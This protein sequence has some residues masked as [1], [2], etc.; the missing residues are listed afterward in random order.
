MYTVFFWCKKKVMILQHFGCKCVRDIIALKYV[1]WSRE[2]TD[3]PV[4]RLHA[5]S[6]DQVTDEKFQ[7]QLCIF[8]YLLLVKSNTKSTIHICM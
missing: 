8:C 4:M 3:Y 1:L 2:Y 5:L 6:N 7:K